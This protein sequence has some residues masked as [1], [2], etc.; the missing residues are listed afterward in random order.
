MSQQ[1]APW[2]A[3]SGTSCGRPAPV[4]PFL[5]RATGC[6]KGTAPRASARASFHISAL[7]GV[8]RVR[9]FLIV[10]STAAQFLGRVVCMGRKKGQD[11]AASCWAGGTVAQP[12]AAHWCQ[13]PQTGKCWVWARQLRAVHLQ[14]EQGAC[15]KHV[16]Q[17]QLRVQLVG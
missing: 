12:R 2:K 11:C 10:V 9:P 13:R 16:S 17:D 7:H 6:C 1:L 15:R 4:A 14:K 8:V 5:L 3:D